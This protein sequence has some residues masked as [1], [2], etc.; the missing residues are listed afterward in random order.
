[1]SKVTIYIRGRKI[2]LYADENY[3]VTKQVNEF[4]ELTKRQ[5]NHSNKFKI[6]KTA[7]NR[8]VLNFLSFPG[9]TSIASYQ[10][11]DQVAMLMNGVP[12]MNNGFALIGDVDGDY[13][14]VFFNGAVNFYNAIKKLT[15]KNLD[16]SDIDH[17]YQVGTMENSFSNT[18]GYIYP[19]SNTVLD[20]PFRAWMDVPSPSLYLRTILEKI[21][22]LTGI[23]LNGDIFTDA[24]FNRCV[25]TTEKGVKLS[26]DSVT[27][28]DN[29]TLTRTVSGQSSFTEANPL[30][31][32]VPIDYY[33]L[34][35]DYQIYGNTN[36]AFELRVDGNSLD[37]IIVLDEEG[38]KVWNVY[39]SDF[40]L[41]MTANNPSG[42]EITAIQD[43]K[44][45][46][47]DYGAVPVVF[48]ELVHKTELTD[49]VRQILV[50]FG[51]NIYPNLKGDAVSFNY[52]NNLDTAE[53]VNIGQF[54][55]SKKNEKYQ[56]GKYKSINQFKYLLEDEQEDVSLGD[57][58]YAH[59]SGDT[60]T[61]FNSV[62]T[63]PIVLS[64]TLLRNT[65]FGADLEP[66]DA[67]IKIFEIQRSGGIIK[68]YSAY[69]FEGKPV[70]D[71]AYY[72]FDNLTF[73]KLL[74]KY[75]SFLITRV[76]NRPIKMVF[77]LAMP[78]LEF[79]NLDFEKIYHIPDTNSMFM[80]NKMTINS[81]TGLTT[82]EMIVVNKKETIETYPVSIF[83]GQL[84][85][86]EAGNNVVNLTATESY[87]IGG[88]ITNYYWEVTNNGV[89][90]YTSDKINLEFPLLQGENRQIC[91]TVTNEQGL[92][93]TRCDNAYSTYS[94][95]PTL[96]FDNY[97]VLESSTCYTYKEFKINGTPNSVFSLNVK[98]SIINGGSNLLVW[99]GGGD[100]SL[101]QVTGCPIIAQI[102][103]PKPLQVTNTFAY[104]DEVDLNITL[105]NNGEAYIQ[106]RIEGVKDSQSPVDN[107]TFINIKDNSDQHTELF[108]QRSWAKEY[109]CDTF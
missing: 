82:A 67:K 16:Y 10:R 59:Y 84:L 77:T 9:N 17:N 49:I 44:V 11:I 74:P 37:A 29:P 83:T 39:G 98:S 6:P 31:S 52:I 23:K 62:F 2:D 91:L 63:Q 88:Y 45:N 48:S 75:Y 26:Q 21:G 12:L 96:V 93:N 109:K 89:V 34:K 66:K 85:Y 36:P 1:M 5:W 14:A 53:H 99:S 81:G 73:D 100:G 86:S 42:I 38:S 56:L 47:I 64:D 51:L 8:E 13:R 97:D 87:S 79:Y 101:C 108:L 30:I 58:P 46:K 106:M 105:D 33:Q 3:S 24:L 92:T 28:T 27:L 72:G 43:L 69:G 94:E 22:N 104:I 15:L 102:V 68:L 103:L 7:N 70:S 57:L 95:T 107:Q 65:L 55:Q 18:E 25:I 54:L 41:I 80:L 40:E 71:F 78:L 32:S 50:T 35:F 61:H 76:F 60:T 90:E 19:V 20:Q 4:T